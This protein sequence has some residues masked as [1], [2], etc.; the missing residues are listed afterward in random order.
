MT[1]L[2]E[3]IFAKSF[4]VNNVNFVN[5]M[6]GCVK[7]ETCPGKKHTLYYVELGG[8]EQRLDHRVV[9]FFLLL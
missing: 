1:F 2:A 8:R 3:I 4:K 7:T 9:G 6:N 5:F